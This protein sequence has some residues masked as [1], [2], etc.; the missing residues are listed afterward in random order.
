VLGDLIVWYIVLC[1]VYSNVDG[2]LPCVWCTV[3]V[4]VYYLV[5]DVQ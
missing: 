3:K 5:Y 4:M 2:A 1:M